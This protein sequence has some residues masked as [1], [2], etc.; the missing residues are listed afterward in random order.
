MLG[1]SIIGIAIAFTSSSKISAS[2]SGATLEY[3]DDSAVDKRI[4]YVCFL[5]VVFL[6]SFFRS[7]KTC[8]NAYIVLSR[9]SSA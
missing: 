2:L 6:Y 7:I 3:E 8:I 5:L 9:I 1:H 4:S